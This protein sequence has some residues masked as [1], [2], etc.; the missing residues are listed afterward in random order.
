MA[1]TTIIKTIKSIHPDSIILVKVG[2]FYNVYGKDSYILSYFFNYK[3]KELEGIVS[4]GFPIESINKIM[5]KLENKKINYLIV[6]RRNNYD[7][8]EFCDNKNLNTYNQI[9]ERAKQY[10]DSKN[11]ADRIYQY[12]IHNLN[13]KKLINQMEKVII[14]EGRKV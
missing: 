7:V 5:A 10:I 6:D 14:N 12:L 8:D 11:R 13:N 1:V 2:K 4:C 9:Y 3:L